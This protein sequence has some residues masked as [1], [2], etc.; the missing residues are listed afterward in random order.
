MDKEQ[1]VSWPEI[2]S[3]IEHLSD[4]ILKSKNKFSS[5]TTPTVKLKFWKKT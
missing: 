4:Q 1:H 5:I 2:D 3:L